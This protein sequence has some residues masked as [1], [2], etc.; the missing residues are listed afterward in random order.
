[1][2]KINEILPIGS[3][4]K[5]I[6]RDSSVMITGIYQ[7]SEIEEQFDYCGVPFPEG[8]CGREYECAFNQ[9]DIESVEYVGF[10]D[11]ERQLMVR[12][13]AENE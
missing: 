11:F 3:V 4:V 2:T 6:Q 10:I 13:V 8:Y 7:V 1:M 5:L 12:Q 9:T